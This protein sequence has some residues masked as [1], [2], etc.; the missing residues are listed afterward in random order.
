[1]K[2]K[3]VKQKLFY[4]GAVGVGVF[5]LFFVISCTWIGYEVKRQCY[6]AKQEYGGDC[7]E[8][9]IALLNDENKG[10]RAR[11]DAVWTLG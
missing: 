6:E 11:N 5:L 1:M 3:N 8:A 9:L 7:V 4:V 2:I 10:F